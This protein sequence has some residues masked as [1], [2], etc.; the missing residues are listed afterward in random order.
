[1]CTVRWE[2]IIGEICGFK[3]AIGLCNNLICI[4]S[5]IVRK[6]DSVNYINVS[7]TW[8]VYF[9]GYWF[10]CLCFGG[11][12]RTLE[13]HMFDDLQIVYRSKDWNVFWAI[14]SSI[15]TKK[16]PNV[17]RSDAMLYYTKKHIT[18]H[19]YCHSL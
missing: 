11:L 10:T 4:Y 3:W 2:S 15:N 9:F 16:C 14:L 12:C 17:Y 1:M 8:K 19:V 18:C 13:V 6:M 7:T 5:L